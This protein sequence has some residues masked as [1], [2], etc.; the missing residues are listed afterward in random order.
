[1]GGDSR[2]QTLNKVEKDKNKVKKD[3]EA[4]KEE[5][6]RICSNPPLILRSDR[7]EDWGHFAGRER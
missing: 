6:K 3:R 4:R 7:I 2:S 1:M 5:N